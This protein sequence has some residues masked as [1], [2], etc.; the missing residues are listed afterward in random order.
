MHCA[1]VNAPEKT[2]KDAANV[3]RNRV[4][5]ERRVDNKRNSIILCTRSG[6]RSKYYKSTPKR[7][8][9]TSITTQLRWDVAKDGP[10][11]S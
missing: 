4:D 6:I 1:V 5:N 11:I 3:V 7:V 10:L 9:E 8:E 2:M